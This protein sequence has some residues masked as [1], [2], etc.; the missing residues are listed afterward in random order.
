MKSERPSINLKTQA[1]ARVAQSFPADV[2]W[3]NKLSNQD[4]DAD[5][6]P[7]SWGQMYVVKIQGLRGEKRKNSVWRNKFA[8]I[9]FTTVKDFQ[10]GPPAIILFC[11]SQKIR[12]IF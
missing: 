10:I 3:N 11:K 12:K 8:T 2:S 7:H 4:S 9:A 5:T 6:W 1:E